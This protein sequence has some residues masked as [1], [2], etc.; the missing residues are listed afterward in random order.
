MWGKIE[1]DIQQ[2]GTIREAPIDGKEFYKMTGE[3]KSLY[4]SAKQDY[5]CVVI[6]D[7]A[8][9]FVITY[10]NDSELEMLEEIIAT[11]KFD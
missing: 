1:M 2:V 9:L 7:F 6:K 5:Y 8:L 11:M 4:G 10:T 3:I